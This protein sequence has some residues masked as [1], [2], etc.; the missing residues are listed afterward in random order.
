MRP[1]ERIKQQIERKHLTQGEVAEMAGI[2]RSTLQK[3]LN[4]RQGMGIERVEHLASV[5]GLQLRAVRK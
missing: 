1:H 2:P 5:L 4:G 3:Y